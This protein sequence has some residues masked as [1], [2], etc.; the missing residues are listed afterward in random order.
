VRAATAWM[1]EQ[2]IVRPD[3]VAAMLLPG[4]AAETP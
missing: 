3:R 2:G 4:A 1:R